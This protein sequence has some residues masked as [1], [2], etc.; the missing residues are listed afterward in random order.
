PDAV[1]GAEAVHRLAAGDAVAGLQRAGL[2]VQPRVDDAAVV[3]RLV[4]AQ[5]VLGLQYD[6]RPG[7]AREQGARGRQ[8]HDP[9]PDDRDL[10]AA[11]VSHRSPT[12]SGLAAITRGGG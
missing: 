5:A 10:V 8:P 9:A 2:V 3:T 12:R 7:A 1:C 11:A 6:Q 4:C